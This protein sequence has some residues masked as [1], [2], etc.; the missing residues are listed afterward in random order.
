M[1]SKPLS[2]YSVTSFPALFLG[3]KLSSHST[4]FFK[5]KTISSVISSFSLNLKLL[6][7]AWKRM[8]LNFTSHWLE[9]RNVQLQH[10]YRTASFLKERKSWAEVAKT[11]PRFFW[12]TPKYQKPFSWGTSLPQGLE[13][14]LTPPYSALFSTVP[15]KITCSTWEI[16]SQFSPL[17]FSL[18]NL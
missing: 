18:W 2:P 17:T 6:S 14:H 13:W 9:E 5:F 1:I 12:I 4:L 3:T 16:V 10:I 7:P 11:E 8:V 15:P